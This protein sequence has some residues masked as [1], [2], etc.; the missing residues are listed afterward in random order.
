MLT[1]ELSVALL[2]TNVTLDD[3][4]YVTHASNKNRGLGITSFSFNHAITSFNHFFN[5]WAEEIR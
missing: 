2:T 1:W 4:T 3:L 5:F